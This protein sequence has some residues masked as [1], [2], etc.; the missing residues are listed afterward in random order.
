M[1]DLRGVLR[2]YGATGLR[3]FGS[4]ARGEDTDASD[5]D[6]LIDVPKGTTLVD[7]AGL[8]LDLREVLGRNVDVL[9]T[10][11]LDGEMRERVLSEAVPL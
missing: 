7:L 4:V 1:R 10:G 11:A 8:M 3:V 2:K 9:T 5:V 6:L